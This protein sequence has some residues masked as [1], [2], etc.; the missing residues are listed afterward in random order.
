MAALNT[1][2]PEILKG[3]GYNQLHVLQLLEELSSLEKKDDICYRGGGVSKGERY[4][5]IGRSSQL[6]QNVP[7]HVIDLRHASKLFHDSEGER[8]KENTN[9]AF[10]RVVQSL[11]QRGFLEVVPY[12]CVILGEFTR[13][14]IKYPVRDGRLRFVMLNVPS[15]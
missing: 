2:S 3:L 13:Q 9:K 7:F 8:L 14:R 11:L 6:Y 1:K 5:S 12:E 10:N 15:A 4:L